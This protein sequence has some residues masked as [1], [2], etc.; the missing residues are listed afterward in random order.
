MIHAAWVTS[1]KSYLGLERR[2]PCNHEMLPVAPA[3]II[4]KYNLTNLGA[5]GL[6]PKMYALDST[7]MLPRHNC[8]VSINAFTD[9]FICNMKP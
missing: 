7:N 2:N 8:L 6:H 4:I 9:I 3:H 1:N 5:D